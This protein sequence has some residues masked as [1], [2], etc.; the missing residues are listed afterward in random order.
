MNGIMYIREKSNF[1]KNALAERMGVTR[2]TVTLWEK[3]VRKPDSK[4]LQWLCD[5]Y[6]LSEQWFGELSEAELNVLNSMQMY[7]YREGDKEFFSFI[8]KED[9]IAIECGSLEPMLDVEYA[10]TLKREK[11]FLQRV[12]QYLKPINGNQAYL[13]DKI[14]VAERGMKEV[15]CYL[16]LLEAVQKVGS[17]GT[18]LKVPFR[19]EIKTSIYAMLIASGQ[20]SLE[21]IKSLFPND[22]SDD[23]GLEI[24]EE[25]LGNLADM[26]G[27]HWNGVKT[28]EM[29]KMLRIRK[30]IRAKKQ[31]VKEQI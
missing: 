30:N 7:R 12:E 28:S 11:L 6:G 22:F 18:F 27:S 26:M 23:P 25:Y 13:C 21:D 2:Q 19:Y 24:D 10:D 15:S 17:E 3:G 14:T 1:S 4:H 8:P 9:E 16:D 29:E 31:V 20:Y 5:F